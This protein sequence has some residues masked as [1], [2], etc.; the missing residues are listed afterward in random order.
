LGRVLGK[1]AEK[2]KVHL[3]AMVGG[4]KRNAIPRESEAVVLVPKAN[5]RAFVG[6]V[7][8]EEA[9]VKAELAKIDPDL[10]IEVAQHEMPTKVLEPESFTRI[11]NL[12]LA[13]PHGVELM[14]YEIEGL[15]ETSTNLA[16]VNLE[17]RSF[18]IGM[19]TRSSVA[20]ALHML[21]ARI[22]SVAALAGA[23]TEKNKPYP[24]WKPNLDSNILKIAKEVY[25]RQFNKDAKVEAC[26]AGLECGI[27]GEK[28]DGMDM[29]SFG[30]TIQNPHSPDER[31]NVPSVETFWKFLKAMLA[32]LA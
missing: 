6:A 8:K 30:P 19:S 22:D 11:L 18:V 24:G 4:S 13:L 32:D 7:G 21:R 31:V 14:S 2:T 5:K 26:H 23:K 28:F 17:P 3:A 12:L 9:I 20:S 10:R 27:I 25:R 15:V 29:I 16:T 1:A